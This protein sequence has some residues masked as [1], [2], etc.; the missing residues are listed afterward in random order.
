LNTK[1]HWE[2]VYTTKAPESVSWYCAHLGTSLAVIERAGVAP[3]ASIVDI[4]GES[5][6][7]DD[8]LLGGYQKLTVLDVS[9]TAIEVT[10]KRLGWAAEQV[11][12][13]GRR[14]RRNRTGTTRL[15]SLV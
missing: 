2:K 10:K 13:V 6:L 1:T 4:G 7:V 12:L 15:R 9:P 14:Y 3:S 5:T 11:A 8:L